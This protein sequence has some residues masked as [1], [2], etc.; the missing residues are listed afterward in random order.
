MSTADWLSG[1]FEAVA[2]RS[3]VV[4]GN[5]GVLPVAAWIHFSGSQTASAPEIT[6]GLG[7][8]LPPNKVLEALTRICAIG[9][10]LELPHPGRP[11]RRVF[12]KKPAPYWRFV[13]QDLAA[14]SA[15][16]PTVTEAR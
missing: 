6:K 8:A 15:D 16:V 3:V 5:R 14:L 12:E 7:G 11:H 9:A 13:E 10:L 1:H 2:A 4:H